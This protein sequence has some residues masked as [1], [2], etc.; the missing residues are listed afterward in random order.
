MSSQMIR[1]CGTCSRAKVVVVIEIPR[2]WEL[3]KFEAGH[4]KVK[5]GGKIHNVQSP[6][7]KSLEKKSS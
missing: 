1:E 4:Q 6:Q 7:H 3:V 2:W 5:V